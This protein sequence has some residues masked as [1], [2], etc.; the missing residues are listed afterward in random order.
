MQEAEELGIT[1]FKF[2]E[3]L[4]G[5]DKF[6]EAQ[7]D[8]VMNHLEKKENHSTQYKQKCLSCQKPLCRMLLNPAW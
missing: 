1:N 6:I 2:T 8:I 4:N 3:G 5:S 7:A